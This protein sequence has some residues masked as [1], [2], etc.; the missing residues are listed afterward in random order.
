M[1][2]DEYRESLAYDAAFW[3]VGLRNPSFPLDELGALSDEVS[4]K[5]RALAILVLLA[6]GESER[7]L[8]NLIRSGRARRT[9]LERLR[10]AGKTD[11]HHQVSGRYRAFVDALAAGENELCRSIASLSPADFR[12]GHEYEDDYCFAQILHR[13][14]GG[15]EPSGDR[16]SGASGTAPLFERW[17]AYRSDDPRMPVCRAIVLRDAPAFEEAFDE[18]LRAREEEITAAKE[19]RQLEEPHVIAE[20]QVYVEGLALLR[21]AVARGIPASGEYRFCPSL[22]RAPLSSRPPEEW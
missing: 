10:D 19:R 1:R 20:R 14:G 3:M 2:L 12:E 21:L 6:Q 7:F 8:H 9:Y 4:K 13:L 15:G 16:E 11:D 5:L 17:E 18:L 22:A